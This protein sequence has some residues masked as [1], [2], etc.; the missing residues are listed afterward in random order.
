MKGCSD[1]RKCVESL[2]IGQLKA[3]VIDIIA[4]DDRI[5]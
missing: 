3:G 1:A 4:P 5:N 2:R